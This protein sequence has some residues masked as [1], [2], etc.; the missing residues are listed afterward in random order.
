MSIAVN[1]VRVPRNGAVR[2]D[3]DVLEARHLRVVIDVGLVTYFQMRGLVYQYFRTP[4]DR[5]IPL[6]GDSAITPYAKRTGSLDEMAFAENQAASRTHFD[7]RSALEL[8]TCSPEDDDPAASPR[9]V[10]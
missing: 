1:D 4:E 10:V 7:P 8:N 3:G 5:N 6:D 2:A 9:T